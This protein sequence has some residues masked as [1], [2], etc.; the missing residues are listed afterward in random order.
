MLEKSTLLAQF[1]HRLGQDQF[2]YINFEDDRFLGFQT[3]DAND[4]YA[5]LLELYGER[6]MFILD[7]VQNIP[8]WEHF[9]RR[10]M[11]LGFKFY[12]TGSNAFAPQPRI[13]H[14]VDRKICADRTVPLFSE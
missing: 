6:K 11:E 14:P 7:E 12:I 4:L 13:G 10:F 2:Y 5:A 1:A 3:D 8:G 9:V